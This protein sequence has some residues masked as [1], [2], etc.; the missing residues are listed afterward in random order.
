MFSHQ[1]HRRAKDIRSPFGRHSPNKKGSMPPNA[2][3]EPVF[4]LHEYA[5]VHAGIVFIIP[6]N[7]AAVRV[8][9]VRTSNYI[10]IVQYYMPS[11]SG[12]RSPTVCS[13]YVCVWACR[14]FVGQGSWRERESEGNGVCR[15]TAVRIIVLLSATFTGT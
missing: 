12:D 10:K 8:S 7:C 1:S 6:D 9:A 11:S 13:G 3:H 15:V 4:K 14:N 2:R 5:C